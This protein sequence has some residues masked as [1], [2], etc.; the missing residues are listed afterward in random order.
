MRIR[1]KS[2]SEVPQPG[3]DF[4]VVTFGGLQLPIDLG[5]PLPFRSRGADE[6]ELTLVELWSQRNLPPHNA[7]TEEMFA[8]LNDRLVRIVSVFFFAVSGDRFRHR[9][10]EDTP[11]L[12]YCLRCSDINNL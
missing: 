10:P 4:D 5:V 2:P 9:P 6:R 8:E 1:S 7:T 11:G 12:Q 3:P